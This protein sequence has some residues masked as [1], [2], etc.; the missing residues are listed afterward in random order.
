MK[1]RILLLILIITALA[2]FAIGCGTADEG[3]EDLSS[4]GDVVEEAGEDEDVEIEEDVDTDTDTDQEGDNHDHDVEEGMAP[5]LIVHTQSGGHEFLRN[6]AG[7][8]VSLEDYRGKIVFLNFWATWCQYCNAEM[9][10]VQKLH[11]EYDDVVVLAVDVNEE[12]SVVEEY[13]EEGGY[14]FEVLMD[15]TGEVSRNYHVAGLPTTYTIR[16][17]GSVSRYFSGML[18]YE[19]MEEMIRIARTGE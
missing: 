18:T 2:V 14:T 6:L 10:D 12:Q 1:N 5:D 19:Q 11:E 3:D 13:I 15:T 9:P 17:D 4:A 7:E 8:E 16:E